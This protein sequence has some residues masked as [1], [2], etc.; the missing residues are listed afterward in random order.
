MA[1]Y[2]KLSRLPPCCQIARVPGGPKRP[3]PTLL[4]VEPPSPRLSS[5]GSA[6]PLPGRREESKGRGQEK[7]ANQQAIKQ[8]P[9]R[10]QKD[11]SASLPWGL[12]LHLLVLLNLPAVPWRH[13]EHV[14]QVTTCPTPYLGD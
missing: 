8:P 3:G 11:H 14:A 10:P 9:L 1:I 7:A 13:Q 6:P 4:D 12:A 5:L 2:R